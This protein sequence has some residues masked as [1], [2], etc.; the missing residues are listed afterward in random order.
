MLNATIPSPN[1]L[2]TREGEAY[3]AQFSTSDYGRVGDQRP[4]Q[5]VFPSYPAPKFLSRYQYLSDALRECDTL[6]QLKGQPFRLMK[7]GGPYPCY[8]CRRSAAANGTL[9]S[10]RIHSPGAL[11]GFADATPVADFLPTGRRIVYGPDGQ[12]KVVGAPNFIVSRTPNPWGEFSFATPI[13]QRYAEAV[14]TAQYIARD[15]GRNTFLCSSLGGDCNRRNP[16]Q[17]L[18]VVY[19]DPGGLVRRYPAGLKLPNSVPGSQI[20]T[21]PVTENEFRELLRESAG[22]SRLGQG[23]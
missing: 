5:I 3:E 8:P 12:P 1:S 19:V 10:L 2:G 15:T 20:S 9:P 14:R 13:P 21:T 11:E 23:A 22:A 17:W 18:P 7:W 6:C 4:Y 16:K